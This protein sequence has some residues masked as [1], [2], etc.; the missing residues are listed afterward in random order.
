[1]KK[2]VY[3]IMALLAL[4]G[5]ASCTQ[6]AMDPLTGKYPVAE[7]AAFAT[8]VNV[9]V[10][11]QDGLNLFSV[12]TGEL[13]LTFV[14]RSWYLG[15]GDY[16]ASQE[17]KAGTFLTSSTY[18][19]KSIESGTLSVAKDGDD[20]VIS[21]VVWLSD[22]SVVK[23]KASGSLQYEE[24]VIE[25]HFYYSLEPYESYGYNMILTDLEGNF[26]ANVLLVTYTTDNVSGS[27]EIISDS[28]ALV[29]GVSFIGMDLSMFGMGVLGDYFD[30]EG[31][32]WFAMGGTV[33]V[34][35]DENMYTIE[36][37]GLTAVDAAGNAYP[38][39]SKVWA[40]AVKA[41]PRNLSYEGWSCL[42]SSADNTENGTTEHTLSLKDASGK[43]AGQVVV[44]TNMLEGIAG[45]FDPATADVTVG[46]YTP[47]ADYSA[48]GY[49]II[50]TYFNIEGGNQLITG[51]AL[52][53]SSTGGKVSLVVND[54]KSTLSNVSSVSFP[55]MTMEIKPEEPKDP[56]EETYTVEGGSYVYTTGPKADAEG[57]IEHY[58]VFSDAV[59]SPIGQILI[60]AADDT[61]AG[62]FPYVNPMTPTAGRFA[63]GIEFDL[64]AYGMG[65]SNLGS[66]FIKDGKT[67]LVNAGTAIVAEEDGKL[68]LTIL[69]MEASTGAS[70]GSE[71]SPFTGLSFTEMTKAE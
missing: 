20:Y 4:T 32:R 44:T 22:G 17:V 57:I 25:P 19:G 24:K 49:G 38:Y 47:G 9:G 33:I 1:M 35:G 55:D 28:N 7:E 31:T 71:A 13:S 6:E 8:L 65:V 59:G 2:I 42:Y 30:E 51:G 18:N 63:G 68:S 29:E 58:F 26:A 67:Y 3:S 66:Y 34:S 40:N 16:V 52:T 70:V 23:V 60:W 64:S 62:M 11:E 12:S 15:T 10:N 14:G 69:G 36:I 61:Y 41:A 21:G 50:G 56:V 27:Y 45:T 48:W 43:A 37:N 53:I 54:V 39:D 5:W 46:R